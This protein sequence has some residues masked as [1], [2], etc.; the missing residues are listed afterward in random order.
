MHKMQDKDVILDSPW[1]HL[2]HTYYRIWST[3]LLF[4]I[5]NHFLFLSLSSPLC[6]NIIKCIYKNILYD[7]ILI[8]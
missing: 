6:Y 1:M 8:K 3:F 4:F 7:Y 2:V 5:L